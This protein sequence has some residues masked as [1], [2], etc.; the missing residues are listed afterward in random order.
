MQE[1]IVKY[2]QCGSIANRSMGYVAGVEKQ[3]YGFNETG[4]HDALP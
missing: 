2:M 4:Y 1:I 3:S